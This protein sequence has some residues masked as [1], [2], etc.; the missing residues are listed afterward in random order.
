[1]HNTPVDV[2]VKGMSREDTGQKAQWRQDTGEEVRG[3]S[4][5]RIQA[6]WEHCGHLFLSHRPLQSL[7]CHTTEAQDE[8]RVAC[9]RRSV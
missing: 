7:P 8:S 6:F 1:M 3:S 2:E 5:G 9:S 4:L